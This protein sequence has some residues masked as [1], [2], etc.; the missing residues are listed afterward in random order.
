MIGCAEESGKPAGR[1]PPPVDTTA[2]RIRTSKAC[3][4]H[5]FRVVRFALVVLRCMCV[6]KTRN[7]K[8]EYLQHRQGESSSN[9]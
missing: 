1:V 9:N 8:E 4:R 5:P 7:R 2:T 3:G 6:W